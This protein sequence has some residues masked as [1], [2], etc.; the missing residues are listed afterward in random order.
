MKWL[1][2]LILVSC[3]F[4]FWPSYKVVQNPYEIQMLP[5]GCM[6]YALQYKMAMEATSKLAPYIWSRVLGIY[7]YDKTG[8]AVTVFVYKNNTFVYNPGVGS[9]L[10]YERPI[11]DPLQLA[12]IIFPYENIRNAYFIEPTLLLQYQTHSLKPISFF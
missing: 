4:L 6:V 7:F 3:F 10:L 9:Y 5:D 2:V 1:P 11:Y 8:H 12:E